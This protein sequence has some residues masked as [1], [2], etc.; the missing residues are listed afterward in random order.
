V[1]INVLVYADQTALE[2]RKEA[3][4]RIGVHVAACPFVL[5]MIDGLVLGKAPKLI[6]LRRVRNELS[7]CTMARK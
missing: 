7:A 4:Q 6:V 5:G 3:F 2:D 1:A